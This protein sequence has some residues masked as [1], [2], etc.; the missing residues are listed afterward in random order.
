MQLAFCKRRF[1]TLIEIMIVMFIIALITGVL[2]YNYRGT[3]DEGKAFKT[4][5]GIEKLETLL[6]LKAAESPS[7]LQNVGGQWRE[8]IRNSPMV[9][10]PDALIKDGWGEDYNVDVGDDGNIVVKSRRYTEYLRTHKESMFKE[11]SE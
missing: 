10:N 4:K 11:S 1:I 9:K 8:V 7:F 2:A 5:T 6:N 3:L